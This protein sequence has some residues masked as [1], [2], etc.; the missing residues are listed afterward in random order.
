VT[1]SPVD[2][3]FGERR[4]AS[5]E[6]KE[7][8]RARRAVRHEVQQPPAGLEARR[9]RSGMSADGA[10]DPRR[11]RPNRRSV[12]DREAAQSLPRDAAFVEGSSRRDDERVG[13]L[14]ERGHPNVVEP[15]E[16]DVLPGDGERRPTRGDA[17]GERALGIARGQR[18]GEDAARG[19]FETVAQGVAPCDGASWK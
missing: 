12:R 18:R 14:A 2:R 19:V 9:G 13:R 17:L 15:I 11:Q 5:A 4:T 1:E 16:L 6:E 7:Y 3:P 10:L 8:E